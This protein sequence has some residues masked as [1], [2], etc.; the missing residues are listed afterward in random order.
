MF[1]FFCLSVSD[2]IGGR[3]EALLRVLTIGSSYNTCVGDVPPG[4]TLGDISITGIHCHHTPQVKDQGVTWV[5]YA[6]LL[7][8]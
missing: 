4:P 1:A 7:C 3:I 2:T 5:F 8:G 6:D